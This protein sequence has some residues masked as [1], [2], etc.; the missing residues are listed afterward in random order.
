MKVLKSHPDWP[1][2][3]YLHEKLKA[4]K[5]YL[6]G[7]AVRDALRFKVPKDFDL[8]T[9]AS[10]QEV[11]KIFPDTLLHAQDFGT[12]MVK[13]DGSL[14]ELTRF[15][16][17]VGYT[18]YRHPD[19]IEF[20]DE[21]EDAIRRDFSVN[22]LFYDLRKDEII[23]YVGGREDLKRSLL[24]F[25]GNAHDRVQEDALRILRGLR[26]H[27]QLGFEFESETE[28]ALYEHKDLLL[29]IS[30]ERV[31]E[32]IRKLLKGENRMAALSRF[33]SF[34]LDELLFA[35]SLYLNKSFL[36]YTDLPSVIA[37]FSPYALSDCMNWKK[38]RFWRLSKKEYQEIESLKKGFEMLK[39]ADN[40]YACHRALMIYP[41]LLAIYEKYPAHFQVFSL[42]LLRQSRGS[43]AV[44]SPPEALVKAQ[45]LLQLGLKGSE[46]SSNL[47]KAY[48]LQIN[49]NLKTKEKVLKILKRI[50]LEQ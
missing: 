25:V 44:Y 45:D 50:E 10:P 36:K 15:R 22:A 4:H 49:L 18:D 3:Q 27:S 1:K 16:K 39:T 37:F 31:M 38:A 35:R 19:Q 8:A 43:S 13:I 34:G 47:E 40:L 46:I 12:A 11:A 5:L 2:L 33:Q 9:S 28:R 32:E 20:C 21:K 41:D 26:F 42:S 48:E 30:R 6:V 14:F 24:R 17:E 7:G 29:Q 23:D